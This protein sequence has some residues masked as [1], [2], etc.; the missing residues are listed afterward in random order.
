MSIYKYFVSR[1]TEVDDGDAPRF[2]KATPREV[3][4]ATLATAL[5]LGMFVA[6]AEKFNTAAEKTAPVVTAPAATTS[7]SARPA[8][9]Y[10]P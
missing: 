9:V 2:H 6:A 4:V 3:T 7:N 10:K 8:T 5:A 1:Q